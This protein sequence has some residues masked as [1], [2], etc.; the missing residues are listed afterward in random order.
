[1][2]FTCRAKC[3]LPCHPLIDAEWSALKLSGRGPEL[4]KSEE[5]PKLGSALARNRGAC[6]APSVMSDGRLACVSPHLG[7][8][9]KIC[10]LKIVKRI[11]VVTSFDFL[12]TGRC[13]HIPSK[14]AFIRQSPA[15]PMS[16]GLEF[17][18]NAGRPV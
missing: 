18:N 17:Q 2:P 4:K 13:A 16:I 1:M 15:R 11:S 10:P 5:L 6:A 12:G 7:N 3:F 8:L 9:S 14:Q